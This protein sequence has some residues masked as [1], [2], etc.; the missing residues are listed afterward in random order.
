MSI[1]LALRSTSLDLFRAGSLK[2]HAQVSTFLTA[3]LAAGAGTGIF[4]DSK[5]DMR[6]TG[7]GAKALAYP[8]AENIPLTT[9]MSFLFRIIPDW[10]GNPAAT[11]DLFQ[12][13]SGPLGYIGA[14]TCFIR[15]DGQLQLLAGNNAGTADICNAVSTGTGLTF[16]SGQPCDIWITWDGTAGAG[17]IKVWQAQN[18]D[19]PTQV[20][21]FTAS[22]AAVAR[23]LAFAGGVA[24]GYSTLSGGAGVTYYL[25]EAVFFDTNED[26]ASYGARTDFIP[27]TAYEG[28]NIVSPDEDDVAE[29]VQYGPGPNSLTGML[30]APVLPDV[31]EVLDG[32]EFG[33]DSGEV[34]TLVLNQFSQASLIG[35]APP[36][37][38]ATVLVVSQGDAG[39]FNLTLVDGPT[40][41][42]I[43]I[44]PGATL[45]SRIKG[46]TGDVV[47][48]NASHTPD[49]DQVTNKGKF[50]FAY[51]R[52]ESLLFK[53]DDGKEIITK[54]T[55]GS[56][57]TQFHGTAILNV[58]DDVPVA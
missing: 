4:G 45:E 6:N 14:F 49:P 33:V 47:F 25:N 41:L 52:D 46:L 7:S 32:V 39:I 26:P 51:T 22:A 15:T 50:Q 42:P 38:S 21:S 40:N 48:A 9:E 23:K 17:K 30:P 2:N 35:R 29:G 56:T 11:Q 12:W 16:V 58:I 53:I 5:I 34:G 3:A 37:S 55:Q 10:T 31:S 27:T 13:G 43:A 24:I 57:V 18:G 28:L 19:V 36:S 1:K 54:L 20:A 44:A 8:G